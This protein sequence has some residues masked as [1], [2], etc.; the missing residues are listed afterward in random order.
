HHHRDQRHPPVA[1]ED[2]DD[3]HYQDE[4]NQHGGFYLIDGCPDKLGVVECHIEDHI[5]GQVFSHLIHSCSHLIGDLNMVGTRLG[6]NDT[7]HHRHPVPSQDILAVGR[8]KFSV[9]H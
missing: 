4:S 7:A 9:A 3:K 6:D 2:E 1:Q 8:I 5:F